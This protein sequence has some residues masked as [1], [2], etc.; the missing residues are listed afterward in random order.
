MMVL[1]CSL[2]GFD[3]PP[4]MR[5]CGGCGAPLNPDSPKRKS[6]ETTK[7]NLNVVLNQPQMR[8]RIL[9][10][11]LEARGQ[12]RNVTVLFVDLCDYTGLAG[13]VEDD[14]LFDFLKIYIRM[15]ADKVYYYEGVV[16]KVIG[17]GLMAIFGAPVAFE[18]TAERGVRAALDMLSGMDELNRRF[19]SQFGDSF[20]IHLGLHSGTVIFGE[21]G[22]SLNMEY[23]T[24]GDTVNLA[25]RLQEAAP[26]DSILVSDKVWSATR[27][28]FD[29]RSVPNLALKGIAHRVDAYALVGQKETK[30]NVR[31][32]E[33]MFA[34]MVGREE[35]LAA[36]QK[37]IDQTIDDRQGRIAFVIG[38]AG[39]GKT[40]LTVELKSYLQTKDV[41]ILQGQSLTYRR[42]V[43][44]WIFLELL[45]DYLRIPP[46][47]SLEWI[48]KQLVAKI[49]PLLGQQSDFVIPYLEYLLSLKHS[50]ELSAQRL[51]LLNAEQLRQH[52]FLAIRSWLEALGHQR[53]LLLIFEDLHWADDVS[54]DLLS[55][56]IDVVDQLPIMILALSRP[57]FEDRLKEIVARGASHLQ[58]RFKVIRLQSLDERQSERLLEV[59]LGGQ[60]IPDQIRDQVLMRANG[61][62]FFIEEMLR[63]YIDQKVIVKQN[64]MW[65]FNSS[66]SIPMTDIPDNLQDLIL[67]RV[68]RLGSLEREV[69]KTAAVIGRQFSFQMLGYILSNVRG[70]DLRDA[71]QDLIN[72]AFI[73]RVQGAGEEE[74]SFRHILTA[75]ALYRTLLREDRKKLHQAV[76]EAIEE[77]YS[78][79][80]DGQIEVLAGHFMRSDRLD[81]AFHYLLL[82]GNKSVRDYANL[83]ARK[84]YLEAEALLSTDEHTPEQ[85]QQVWIGLGDV[86]TFIGEY[87]QARSYYQIALESIEKQLPHA[88][89]RLHSRIHRKIA[90]TYERQ[91]NFEVAENHLMHARRALGNTAF[92]S[93]SSKAEILNDLGWIHFLRGNFAEAEKTLTTGLNLVEGSEH[94]DV[95]AS[96]HNRLGALAYQRRAYD[97]AIQHVSKSLALRKTFGD[98]SGVARLNNNLGLL[99]M[100]TGKYREAEE[101]F[102]QGINLLEKVGDAEGITLANINI[103]LV[104]FDRGDLPS[105]EAFLEKARAK[106]ERIGHRFYLALACLY[107]GRL[108]TALDRFTDSDQLLKFSLHEF[109]DLGSK[110]N[111]IDA[112]QYIAEN[113]LAW[114][115]LSAAE[116]WL[117]RIRQ[118]IGSSQNTPS[119]ATVQ[120]GRLLRLEGTL[121]RYQGSTDRAITTL[122]QSKAILETAN[123]K[124]EAGRTC[125]ELG[126]ANLLQGRTFQAFRYF[127]EA[128]SIFQQLGAERDMAKV[129]KMLSQI[130]LARSDSLAIP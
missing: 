31:G 107:L 35:E 120:L 60:A 45:L 70:E 122:L 91:G 32:L 59:L 92:L 93:P 51:A 114:G 85:A 66:L 49:Q 30:G 74:Y 40:R 84:Y 100:M 62:P 3:N 37:M 20:H 125:F 18:N 126:C 80:L 7:E 102:F 50:E 73:Y 113:Y 79:R 46:D 26:P 64:G 63:M 75:D 116:E 130:S 6:L 23:T 17:D 124:L 110:D 14:D 123:E 1:H 108:K 97:E 118:V 71:L 28:L 11:G 77:I 55:Y 104:K 8:D 127:N 13:K 41:R 39:I 96:I 112:M 47:A 119:A 68:D 117:L 5:F 58:E 65:K 88:D 128:R 109:D 42:S 22:S 82:A 61:V 25:R 10:A 94:F 72:K 2:C 67:A 38:E 4:G 33:G 27:A 83:Q 106:A 87:E 69:L 43:S 78:D 12:R 48:Q 129:N 57:D 24:I 44:Y 36:L 9:Q 95:V 54:L 16:D 101:Y 90:Q 89:I 52:T 76:G 105:A 81:K 103:G 121:A 86:L 29:Y 21:I 111:L 98:L 115:D 99:S 56:L 19:A 34:P 15:L 53:P